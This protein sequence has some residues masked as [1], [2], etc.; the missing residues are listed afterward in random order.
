MVVMAKLGSAKGGNVAA[1]QQVRAQSLPRSQD[2]QSIGHYVP[3]V[4]EYPTIQ[5]CNAAS[6]H[7]CLLLDDTPVVW[8]EWKCVRK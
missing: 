4:A 5:R 2:R 1:T 8:S 6:V 3:C 7:A